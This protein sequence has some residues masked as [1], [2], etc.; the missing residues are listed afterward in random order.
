MRLTPVALALALALVLWLLL[1]IG[2]QTTA[3]MAQPDPQPQLTEYTP[4]DDTPGA[5]P[6][7]G[8][9][10]GGGVNPC[11]ENC[12]Y[13]A[14]SNPTGNAQL[15]LPGQD[16]AVAQQ[17]FQVTAGGDLEWSQAL[18][19]GTVY[20][21]DREENGYPVIPCPDA[22]SPLGL[23]ADAWED[24]VR[25]P[26]HRARI[27]PGRALTGNRAYLVLDSLNEDGEPR[28]GR[29]T[30]TWTFTSTATDN[31]YELRARAT[32]TVDWGDGTVD[33]GITTT[34]RE[35]GDGDGPA[36]TH[37]YQD[38]GEVEVE[39]AATWEATL[40][41]ADTGVVVQGFPDLVLTDALELPIDEVQAIRQR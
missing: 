10:G 1:P 33:R 2:A 31:D 5:P 6:G 21:A 14:P 20:W 35:Y 39:V 25:P 32:Y 29:R 15:V 28:D 9:G 34:G 23:A 37:V 4:G 11:Y 26:E 19:Q 38:K 12:R 27:E 18:T 41:D 16:P 3:A 7:P 36:I 30:A 22:N 13:D 8:G 24:R 17:C 40:Y